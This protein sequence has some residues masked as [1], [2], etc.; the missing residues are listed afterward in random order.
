M[1]CR[2][3]KYQHLANVRKEKAS[4]MH[5][6][7]M[8]LRY[9]INCISLNITYKNKYIYR[10][11]KRGIREISYGPHMRLQLKRSKKLIQYFLTIQIHSYITISFEEK[12]ILS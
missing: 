6:E 9:R 1:R 2:T 11:R 8:L 10:N 7:E 12:T 3:S 4:S 5:K